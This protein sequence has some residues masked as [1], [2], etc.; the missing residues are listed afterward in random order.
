MRAKASVWLN[1]HPTQFSVFFCAGTQDQ[2]ADLSRDTPHSRYARLSD[3]YDL[4]APLD[5]FAKSMASWME[6]GFTPQIY[7]FRRSN[8]LPR[9]QLSRDKFLKAWAAPATA[10]LA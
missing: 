6:R 2:L 10:E 5:P 7:V 3:I 4:G 1:K 8:F 9:L